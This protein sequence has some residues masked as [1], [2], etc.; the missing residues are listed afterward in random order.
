ML[1]S[2]V[3][4]NNRT[5]VF[6]LMVLIVASGVYSYVTLPREAA[7]DVPIPFVL[8][9]TLYEGVS[10]EDVESAVT[11]KIERELSGLKGVKEITSSSAEGMSIINIEFHP[12]TRIEDA[13][14]YVRDKVDLAKA[15]LPT[16]AEEP[17]IKEINV[18]EFPFL[19]LNIAGRI[20][21]V[22]L[23]EIADRLE[24]RIE[25][26]PGVLDVEVLGG[27]E[28]EIRLAMNPDRVAA[29]ELTVPELVDVIPSENVNTSA[30]AVETPGTKFNVRVPAELDDP[31]EVE[32]LPLTERDG[33]PVYLRD[34][35][36]VLDTFK[37]RTS[38]ARLDGADSVTLSV[39]KTI[40]ANI[41]EVSDE[42]KAIL[43][44]AR[45]IVPAGVAID[46][47]LD[48]SKVI[49]RMVGDL[50]NNVI[51]GLI[52][53]VLVLVLFMGWRTSL[54]V[55][56]AIPMSM[57]MS[58]CLLDALGY[59]LN[60]VVL[61]SLILALGMLVDNA[62]VIVE[63]IFRHRQLGYGRLEAAIKG[64]GE[65][66]WPVT[67]STATTIAA[68]SPLLFWPG[69][70]G[71]FMKYLPITLIIT[72]SSSL[73]VALVISPTVCSVLSGKVRQVH[74]RHP[75]IGVYRRVLRVAMRHW[76]TTLGLAFLMLAGVGVYYVRRGHGR[77]LFPSTDPGQALINIR[78]PQ[79]TNIADSDKLARMIAE[80]IEAHR[81]K[82]D[83]V[84]TNVGSG[85]GAMS[86]VGRPGGSHVSNLTVVFPDYI[87]RKGW[88]SEDVV[89]KM[90][91]QVLDI[92]GAEIKVE[93]EQHGPPTGAAVVVRIAGEDFKTLDRL[94]SEAM[95]LI[96]DVPG[97]VNARSD[98]ELTRPELV[99]KVDRFRANELGVSPR[100]IGMFLKTCLFGRKVGTYR[101]FND[102]YDIT[103]RLAKEHRRGVQD[104]LRLSIP[105]KSGRPV[106]LYS[107]GR[108]DYRGGHGTIN[109]VDQKRVVT[110]TGD[111]E[112]R[113][114][115]LVLK[116]VQSRLHALGHSPLLDRDLADWPAFARLLRD[117]GDP[118]PAKR[119][120]DKLDRGAREA[121]G[122]LAGMDTPA[123]PDEPGKEFA[124]ARDKLIAGINK[125]IAKKDFYRPADFAGVEL[126]EE[127]ANLL[128]RKRSGSAADKLSG[129]EIA[130]LNRLL[131]EA[132][133]AA[134]VAT[135]KRLALPPGY[136]IRYAGQK[137]ESDRAQQFLFGRALPFALLLIV[138]I[139]VMQFNTLSPP[140]II[141]TTV[142]LSFIGVLT[143]LLICRQPFGTIMTGVGVISL[144]GVVVNNAIVL[145]DYTR[146]LQKQGLDVFEATLQAGATR[147]RPVLLTAVTTILG[148]IPMATGVS[149]DFHKL[150]L[151]D[152]LAILVTRSESSQMWSGM[153]IA[154]IFG[155][156]FATVL[157]LVVV[158]TIYTALYRA[159]ARFGFGGL[160]RSSP[161]QE[162]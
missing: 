71:D 121:A 35:A 30:G 33:K 68:F 141:M 135:R 140:L 108:L 146:K 88:T 3:A 12:N 80:R 76:A 120:W 77:E 14:Q 19:I 116:D 89:R 36:K 132:A 48:R 150:S 152:P 52:L 55:A 65:V 78:K 81:E 157:T 94:A 8:I 109:R 144:A 99:F 27:L 22:R 10:P 42:I 44:E 53:V 20:E 15:D 162:A 84:I 118:G 58:F 17:I 38:Y 79:G 23:K 41:L 122:A 103:V 6:V 1:L 138:L 124:K 11:I 158:P 115:T 136:E 96:A 119:I 59:T 126:T 32:R 142:M 100:A 133:F 159:A 114:D 7:P 143:G 25:R 5:T 26:V 75:V 137:E 128:E 86:F 74:K 92:A 54:I 156:A 39:R 34:V 66:A 49:R 16:E 87:D 50:E 64:T 129:K 101:Q 130:R 125:L 147:L 151:T 60:M 110:I 51:T 4:V 83:N 105:S 82:I 127:A 67:T 31:E 102:E 155:L 112:G 106:P 61:F 117:G 57:L 40:G 148:L 21:L 161:A 131:L 153:A 113:L 62:I 91:D 72:L 9:S 13:L 70:M 107:L 104:L 97:L 56:M 73:F 29:Y 134:R 28:R 98:L 149:L 90:H 24:D 37:D 2:N 18:A 145:L 47:T 46:V 154:V 69:I 123:D 93:K 43:A 85:G 111:A 160:Q 95:Q 63:N 139:L 45:K